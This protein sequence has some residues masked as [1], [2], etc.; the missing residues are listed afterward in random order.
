MN[1]DDLNTLQE[2]RKLMKDECISSNLKLEYSKAPRKPVELPPHDVR[3]ARE[4]DRLQ[5]EVHYARETEKELRSHWARDR[6]GRLD[7]ERKLNAAVKLL[8]E[9]TNLS[10]AEAETHI[11]SCAARIEK[12]KDRVVATY[13]DTMMVNIDNPWKSR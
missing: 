12:A 5:R 13:G 9:L 8:A 10:G 6:S 2:L 11:D 4:I 1:E 7:A 3:L